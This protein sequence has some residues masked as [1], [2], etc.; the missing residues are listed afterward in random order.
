MDKIPSVLENISNGFQRPG[1]QN[2]GYF[3]CLF[4]HHSFAY[5]SG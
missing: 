1:Q 4:S 5:L 3:G 2:P